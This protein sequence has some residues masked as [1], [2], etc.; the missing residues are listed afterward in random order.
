MPVTE[1]ISACRS[2]GSRGL[3]PFLDLGQMP[4]ADALENETGLSREAARYPLEVAFCPDCSLVQILRSPPPELLFGA[5]YPYFSSFSD[6][7]VEHARHFA[8]GMIRRMGLDGNARVLE[9]ASNDGYL[10]R[11][12][13]AAGIPVLGVDPAPGPAAAAAAAGIPTLQCFFTPALADRLAGEGKAADLI[14]ANNVLAHVPDPNTLLAG[15]VRLLKPGGLISVEVPYLRDLIEQCEFDTIYHE[16]HSYFSVT[17]LHTL[18]RRHGLY[19]QQVE[20]L[21]THGGSLRVLAAFDAPTGDAIQRWLREEQAAGLQGFECYRAFSLRVSEAVEAIRALLRRLSGQGASIAAYGAAAKGA[22][23]LNC[24]G[25][26]AR[27]CRF[28]AD[29]NRHKQGRYMPGV[30]L[31]IRAASAL[32]EEMP[33]YTLLLS[34]N[35]AGEILAQ[36]KAYIERGGRFIIPIP[37]PRIVPDEYE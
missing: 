34:W 13:T 21:G 3:L 15:M 19:L 2:C 4:L 29:R 31:P 11:H 23:L 10:L 27:V 32:L 6:A 36:Q 30:R 5:D 12:F 35:W 17:A 9:I 16:H 24:L 1:P 28:V 26:E 20:A 8:Q 14:C 22:V 7:W 18:F 37:A 33:D 25:P